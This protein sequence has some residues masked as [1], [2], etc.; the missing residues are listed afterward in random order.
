MATGSGST[1][2]YTVG[3]GVTHD[4]SRIDTINWTVNATTTSFTDPSSTPYKDYTSAISW[5][6]T[7][8]PTTN[9]VNSVSFDWFD[10]DDPEKS[11]TIVLEV[12]NRSSIANFTAADRQWQYWTRLCQFLSKESRPSTTPV[13]PS[14]SAPFQPIVGAGNGWVADVGLSYKLLKT[15]TVS[16]NAA[17]SITPTLGGALQQSN[18]FGMALSHQINQ[19]S[20]VRFTSQFSVTNS[21]SHSPTVYSRSLGG[22]SEFL[23]ASVSYSYR[24][25]RDWATNVSYTYLQR[26]DSTGT[27]NANLFF[28]SLVL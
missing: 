17:N 16:F 1:N 27:V 3:G 19:L 20:D 21:S 14:S 24:L 13:T 18:S 7:L 26:N 2:I 8:S 11:Q 25:T 10:Q 9:W 4:L 23:S 15:T 28:F 12:D 6:R 5:N 22:S